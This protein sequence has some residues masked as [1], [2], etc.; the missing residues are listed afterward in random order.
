LE[1]IERL[2]EILPAA[3]CRA[4]AY[5]DDPS[6]T[7]S[8]E[9]VQTHISYV[10]ISA[11]RVYKL[12]KAVRPGFLDF[13]T[14]EARNADCLRE[15]AL[16]RRLAPDVYLGV[17]PVLAGADR[18][19]VGLPSEELSGEGLEH[20]VVMR[21]LAPG[22]DALS[23]LARGQLRAD[24][25]DAI[26]RRVARFHE[27]V[28]LGAPAPFGPAEWLQRIADPV[29]ETLRMAVD[30]HD[31]ERPERIAAGARAL[32]EAQRDRF[33]ARRRDGR[34][35]DGHGDLHLAHIWFE[36][37]SEDA[38]PLFID[39]IEFSETLRRIDAASEVAFLAMDLEYRGERPLAERFL[40]HYAR[41]CDDFDLY[42]VLHY[43]ICY[44]AAVRAKC[45]VMAAGDAA[46]SDKQRRAATQSASRHL[47]LA[48]RLLA[49][50]PPGPLL[51]LSGV[52]GT[53]K[54]CAAEA[55]ADELGGVVV[56]SDRLRKRLAGLS[57]TDRRFAGADQGIYTREWSERV[58]RGLLER[59]G[60]IIASGR[61][62]ILDATFASGN[63][64]AMAR[65][66]ARS[67]RVPFCIL[68]TR[69]EPDV[70]LERLAERQRREEDP[71]DAGPEFY[72][73][74]VAGFEPVEEGESD[75]HLVIHTEA[76]DW[77][78]EL[79]QRLKSLRRTGGIAAA[80]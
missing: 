18:A 48:E 17:A 53:G 25:I 10:F 12:R 15:I 44:R 8:L 3:L 20:C 50:R 58:Y 61:A 33:E 45:A 11:E 42:G 24:H 4:D 16:N 40:R 77:Q 67:L 79:A 59:A 74:S 36:S 7:R 63:Q 32:L 64:R 70:A 46:L 60:P 9:L 26:S 51:I 52:V 76:A 30:P 71:S 38:D 80:A 6:A 28:R 72:E 73:R 69:C 1:A 78:A 57:A 29:E 31:P 14:R 39:C 23:L 34:A 43:Y 47:D 41:A 19:R 5:P 56:S 66:L 55:A 21:R 68:E 37:E 62:A 35:V 2:P 13:G 49:P 65:R 75:A 54:S 22:R 27:T